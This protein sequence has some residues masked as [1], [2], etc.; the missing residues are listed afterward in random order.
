MPASNHSSH[1]FSIGHVALSL[2]FLLL[3]GAAVYYY[4]TQNETQKLQNKEF[5]QQ[6]LAKLEPGG[7]GDAGSAAPPS[8]IIRVGTAYQG[9]KPSMRTFQGRLEEIRNTTLSSEVTG[10]VRELPVEVG[11]KVKAGETLIVKIDD[12]WAEFTHD[13]AKHE[14]D[15]MTF[16]LKYEETEMERLQQLIDSRAVSQSEFLLQVNKVDQIR[17]NLK[18]AQLTQKESAEKLRRTEIRAPFDGYIIRKMTETGSLLAPGNPIVQI[19]SSGEIDAVANIVQTVVDQMSIGDEITVDIANIGLKVRGKVHSIVPYAPMLGARAFPVHIRL[20]NDTGRLMSG[21]SV[22]ALV[23]ESE[24]KPGVII[25]VEALVDKADGRTVWVALKGGEEGEEVTVQPVPVK[26]LAH[27][28]DSC[29]VE[30]ETEEGKEILTDKALVVIEGSE[31][32]TPGQVVTVREIDPRY[33][34]NLPTGSGH[35]VIRGADSE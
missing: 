33:L 2:T 31:R 22:A 27:A 25:P 34:E 23:P 4:Q 13:A 20:P 10:L 32:I 19:V 11:D 7:E 12:T 6:Q 28:G 35:A 9:E 26:L 29:S 18:I 14:V 17:T 1:S 30:A 5:L 16:T 15:L 21:M 8:V 24:A 3:G